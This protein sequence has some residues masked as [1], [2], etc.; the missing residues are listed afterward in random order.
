MVI[1]GTTLAYTQAA[2]YARSSGYLT[3]RLVDIGDH[4]KKGQLL[5]VIDAPD[6]DQQVA[7][8]RSAV[9]TSESILYQ[10]Q[11]PTRAQ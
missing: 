7:Q 5:A 2:I 8:A 10:L 9:L 1:P 11:G 6:L 3:R 4:V